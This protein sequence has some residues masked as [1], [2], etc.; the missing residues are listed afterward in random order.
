[1]LQ[2]VSSN[3]A[4]TMADIERIRCTAALTIYPGMTSYAISG[5][6]NSAFRHVGHF[7]SLYIYCVSGTGKNKGMCVWRWDSSYQNTSPANSTTDIQYNDNSYSIIRYKSSETST[8]NIYKELTIEK[9]EIKIIVEVS[10]RTGLC[11]YAS[12]KSVSS[13]PISERFG[14][15]VLTPSC[16]TPQKSGSHFHSVVIF[17]PKPGLFGKTA[18]KKS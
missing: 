6:G 17:T 10:L 8:S 18:P 15:F 14:F 3:K 12:G 9:D 2:N 1:M 4:L 16:P 7:L 13:V 5:S 11:K